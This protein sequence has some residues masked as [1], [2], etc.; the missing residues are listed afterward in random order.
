MPATAETTHDVV[1][2]GGGSGGYACALRAAELGPDASPSSRRT[3]SAAPACT[4]AA[5]RPRRCCTRPRSPTAPA[6]PRASACAPRSSGIDLPGR[7]RLPRGCGRPAAQGPA[8]PG[9]VALGRLRRGRGPPRGRPHGRRRRPHGSSAATWCSRP[10]PT[11]A[12]LPGL[13]IG[14]PVMTSDGA[15]ALDRVPDRVVV[16]GGGVI[17]VE[18]ASVM[19]S[20]GA[21][22]TIVEALPRL[23][24][25]EDPAVSKALERAFRKR[26]IAFRTGVRF[27]SATVD[28]DTVTVRL[29]GGDEIVADLLLVAVGRGPGHRRAR[30][31]GGRRHPRPR[32]RRHR[33][34]AAAPPPR[35]SMPWATSCPASSSRTAGSP[36]ASSSPRTSPGSSPAPDRRVDDPARHLL[37]PRD[38][39]GRAHRGAGPRGA[40]RG[41]DL[42]VQPRRQRQVADPAHPGLRQ[43]RPR[44][45]R[46]RRRRPHGRRRGSA[47]RSARP[48]SSSAGRPMPRTS[49]HSCTPT[50]RRTRPSAKPT[51]RSPGNPSTHTTRVTTAATAHEGELSRCQNA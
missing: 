49:R 23:V 38:R 3:S 21:E 35:A 34:A 13:E 25:A 5:S 48:S 36:R 17:G 46:T 24:A 20:F 6:R 51:W 18:F 40:R 47:S 4:A 14:G 8:G 11:P 45:G 2:L 15:L 19:R 43:A 39:L 22:V 33:R 32:L 37:R 7:H 30:L 27:E 10:A 1:V 50:P 28:G 12:R 42:R 26:G 9:V 44:Q 29:E 16:L 41:R 31:R